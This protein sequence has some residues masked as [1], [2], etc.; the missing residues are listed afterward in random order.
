MHEIVE[1]ETFNSDA[2]AT[3]LPVRYCHRWLRRVLLMVG[4]LCCVL[5][6]GMFALVRT[7]QPVQNAVGYGAGEVA[8]LAHMPVQASTLADGT[9][10]ARA[11]DCSIWIDPLCWMQNA[12]SSIAAWIANG[13]MQALQPLVQAI[14]TSSSNFITQTP[15]CVSPIDGCTPSPIDQTLLQFMQWGS[16]TVDA[17]ALTFI[18][19]VVGYNIAIGRQI[20]AALYEFSEAIPRVALVFLAATISPLIIQLF[21]DLN[22]I[23]CQGVIAMAA[24]TMLTN[25]IVGLIGTGLQDGWLIW[26]LVVT[27]GVMNMLLVWQMLVRLVFLI[28]LVAVAPL[29][30]I[31]LALPQTM[32]WGRLWLSN[33]SI[34]VFVQF[35]QVCLLALGGAV[36]TSVIALTNP[37]FAHVA[38]ANILVEAMVAIA[39]LY[40]TLRFPGMLRQWAL[41]HVA[42][43]AG[44]AA[45]DTAAGAASYVADVAPRL[46]ALLV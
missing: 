32:S 9:Q 3:Q 30:L 33:F 24:L 19:G 23:L 44:Q 35:M 28:F 20:G 15:L 10:T 31:C 4:I 17:T 27:L 45:L 40:L 7:S 21:L 16:W 8:G 36:A 43:Q 41:R 14:D 11:Q 34:T 29:G 6:P 2:G 39:L 25:I 37:L 46:V 22:N 5:F 42:G 26:L 13:I 12:I 1:S 38:N 18:L